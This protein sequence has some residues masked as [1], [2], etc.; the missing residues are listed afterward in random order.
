MTVTDDANK[1]LRTMR[2]ELVELRD[3]VRLKLHLGS[4]DLKDRFHAVEP[5][6]RAFE[7]RAEQATADVSQ[8]VREGFVHLKRALERI[9]DELRSSEA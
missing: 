9:R 4:M 7:H 6:V 1:A 2:D 5:D 3:V 8:E